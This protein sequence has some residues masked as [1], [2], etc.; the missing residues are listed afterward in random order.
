MNIINSPVLVSAL[1]EL[2]RNHPA[3]AGIFESDL[4]HGLIVRPELTVAAPACLHDSKIRDL[5]VLR[6]IQRVEIN[7]PDLA[8][9]INR[10]PP[11]QVRQLLRKK[12][13]NEG[14]VCSL[15][16]RAAVGFMRRI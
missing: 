15:K 6:A 12:V 7:R 8:V 4:D 2:E 13:I 3:F 11:D 10:V 14:A 16:E 5:R 1:L 9:G